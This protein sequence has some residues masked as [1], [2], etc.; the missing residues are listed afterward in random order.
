MVVGVVVQVVFVFMILLP[1]RTL[2]IGNA[3]INNHNC[4]VYNIEVSSGR[5]LFTTTTIIAFFFCFTH[6]VV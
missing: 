1:L 2:A 4:F 6:F 3:V 5:S